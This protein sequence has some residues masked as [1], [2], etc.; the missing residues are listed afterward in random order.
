MVYICK[1]TQLTTSLAPK[2]GNGAG[3]GQ[4]TG[5]GEAYFPPNKHPSICFEIFCMRTMDLFNKMEFQI[6]AAQEGVN[7]KAIPPWIH[8]PGFISHPQRKPGLTIF[9]VPPSETR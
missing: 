7:W 5:G 3:T 9:L 6:H 2:E 1:E 8:P 4:G